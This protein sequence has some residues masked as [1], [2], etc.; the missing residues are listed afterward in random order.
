MNTSRHIAI[1]AFSLI[2]FAAHAREPANKIVLSCPVSR[3]PNLQDVADV[4]GT[5][6][7]WA[8]YNARERVLELAKRACKRGADYVS[9][10]SGVEPTDTVAQ[11]DAKRASG[12]SN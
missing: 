4:V 2:A 8:S 11:N 7:M 1:V 10:V 3:T 5:T 9:I 6:N 12:L